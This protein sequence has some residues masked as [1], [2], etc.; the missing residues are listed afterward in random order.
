MAFIIEDGTDTYNW[1]EGGVYLLS[2]YDPVRGGADGIS[3]RQATELAART[4]NLHNR[5]KEQEE[6]IAT[7]RQEIASLKQ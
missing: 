6:E 3:N 2:E 7:L 5:M 1:D 4:R